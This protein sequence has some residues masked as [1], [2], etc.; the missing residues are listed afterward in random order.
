MKAHFWFASCVAH[1]SSCLCVCICFPLK[2]PDQKAM[3]SVLMSS[4]S[5][6]SEI[7]MVKSSCSSIIAKLT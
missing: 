4:G 7:E 6:L 5:L 1:F 3:I 2:A